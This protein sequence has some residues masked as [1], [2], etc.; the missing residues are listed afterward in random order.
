[1]EKGK[2]KG[3]SLLARL[4]G[5]FGPAES[6]RGGG[7]AD[8]PAGPPAGAGAGTTSWVQAHVPARRGGDDVRGVTGGTNRPEFDRR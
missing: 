4:G 2:R 6:G 1:M 5:D 3:F 8:G 7:G